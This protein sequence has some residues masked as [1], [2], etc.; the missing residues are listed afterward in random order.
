MTTGV[1]P[2]GPGGAPVGCGLFIIFVMIIGVATFI[3]AGF[4]VWDIV[5]ALI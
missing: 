4:L 2:G 1:F 3:G 5:R